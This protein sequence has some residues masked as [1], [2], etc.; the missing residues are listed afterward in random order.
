MIANDTTT[1]QIERAKCARYVIALRTL[2][3]LTLLTAYFLLCTSAAATKCATFDEHFHLAGGYSYSVFGDFRIQPENGNL[4][5][6]WSSLPL[7]FGTW[8][9]PP[10]QGDSWSTSDLFVVSDSFFYDQGNNVASM[11]WQG[12]AMIAVLGMALGA[13]IFV[14]A[15]R[16]LGTGAAF[17]SLTL[18]AFFPAALANGGVITSDMAASLFFLAGVGAFWR[19][20]HDVNWATMLSCSLALSALFLSKFSAIMIIPM[21]ALMMVVQLLHGRPI[22]FSWRR[23]KSTLHDLRHRLLL[24]VAM[25]ATQLAIVYVAIWSAYE[26]R[27]SMFHDSQSDAR[28]FIPWPDLETRGQTVIGLVNKAR[29]W[30]FL[31]EAYLYGFTHTYCYAQKRHAFLNGEYSDKG[32]FQFFPYCFAVKTPLALFALLGAGVVATMMCLMKRDK[33][34]DGRRE[35]LQEAIYPATPLWVLFLVYWSFV[36]PSN[37]NIGHRHILP[38]YSPLFVLAGASIFWLQSRSR[39]V[40]IGVCLLLVSYVLESLLSWPNYLAYFNQVVGNQRESYRHLVDSSLDWGQDLPDLK[41]WLVKEGLDAQDMT[42]VYLSYFGT[43]EPCYYGIK[44]QLLP[45]FSLPKPRLFLKKWQPGIYCVSAT[46]LQ[47]TYNI[48]FPGP[49]T[50]EYEQ[51][52]D[53]VLQQ[54]RLLIGATPDVRDRE[55]TEREDYWRD[56]MLEYDYLRMGRLSALLRRREPDDHINFSILIYRLTQEDLELAFERQLSE[57]H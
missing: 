1:P 49:W 50:P 33:Q 46:M 39:W 41:R 28:P 36:I 23:R 6:R 25:I 51:H 52:Y 22:T 32:R 19:V 44:A 47:S 56:F 55:L 24:L 57:W 43:A 7:L 30:H 37:L 11:L 18:Y 15:Q 31:P 48:R 8:T 20:L 53:E 26:F 38:S 45:G 29:Q 3:V 13:L 2:G 17:V 35:M 4:P 40:G 54:L 14:W 10:L 16:L 42:D 34:Q 21:C 12:R 27:Y 9:F 5:Q